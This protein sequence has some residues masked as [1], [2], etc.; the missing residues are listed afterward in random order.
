MSMVW[1]A[2]QPG[3]SKVCNGVKLCKDSLSD[4]NIRNT[5]VFLILLELLHAVAEDLYPF[6]HLVCLRA[7]TA[8]IAS[9]WKQWT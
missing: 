3:N 2:K 1:T 7:G 9:R 8:T 4:K 6:Q 5:R